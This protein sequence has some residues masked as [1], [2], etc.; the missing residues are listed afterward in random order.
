MSHFTEATCSQFILE[1]NYFN[2]NFKMRDCQKSVVLPASSTTFSTFFSLFPLCC[3]TVRHDIQSLLAGSQ[4]HAGF[5]EYMYI[6]YEQ[7]LLWGKASSCS[8]PS[9]FHSFSCRL[10]PSLSVALSCCN[11]PIFSPQ[12]ATKL[13]GSRRHNSLS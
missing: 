1:T 10:S 5:P 6:M 7:R 13:L 8:F 9:Q 11:L 3:Y 12:S 4:W 2:K